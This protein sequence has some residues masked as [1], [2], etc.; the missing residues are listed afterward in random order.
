MEKIKRLQDLNT[1]KN[2]N[3]LL[4]LNLN[5]FLFFYQKGLVDYILKCKKKNNKNSKIKID[6]I[7][8]VN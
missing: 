3:Q 6:N 8:K 4:F 7:K 1:P 2:I 5:K